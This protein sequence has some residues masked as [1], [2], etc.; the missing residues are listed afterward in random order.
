MPVL[1]DTESGRTMVE[2]EVRR[3][4]P[5]PDPLDQGAGRD[6]AAPMAVLYALRSGKS[7]SLARL[8]EGEPGHGSNGSLDER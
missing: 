8:A 3:L 6:G 2:I 1:P 7:S 5:L 4:D